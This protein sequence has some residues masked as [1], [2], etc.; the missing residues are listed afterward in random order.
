MPQINAYVIRLETSAHLVKLLVSSVTAYMS[1]KKPDS[2]RLTRQ[3]PAVVQGLVSSLLGIHSML[4][5]TSVEICLESSESAYA[6][7]IVH[8]LSL[9]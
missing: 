5:G 1:L 6:K 4:S 2:M 3:V 9:V 8:F 7:A